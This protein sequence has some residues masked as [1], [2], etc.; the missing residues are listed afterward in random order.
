MINRE[1]LGGGVSEPL[2]LTVQ[3][4]SLGSAKI[5]NQTIYPFDSYSFSSPPVVMDYSA[6]DDLSA[7]IEVYMDGRTSLQGYIVENINV[8][9]WGMEY[10]STYF[11]GY[12]I[13]KAKSSSI[14]WQ[15]IGPI[16]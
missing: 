1:L 16:T 15:K 2:T 11:R 10:S 4:Y 7:M 13:D 14:T 3:P 8:T 12:I 6:I 5:G 9:F